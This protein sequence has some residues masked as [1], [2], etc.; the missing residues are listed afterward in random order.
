MK[1][2]FTTVFILVLSFNLFS[3]SLE[4]NNNPDNYPRKYYSVSFA[5]G[6]RT[7]NA[8]N[9]NLAINFYDNNN[10]LVKTITSD[11]KGS[12]LQPAFYFALNKGK[13]TGL[14]HR[15]FFDYTSGKQKSGGMGYSLSWNFPFQFKNTYLVLRTGVYAMIGNTLLNLKT[16]DNPNSDFHIGDNK[17]DEK[18]I[19][20]FLTSDFFAV[21][22]EIEARY[23]VNRAI[24]AFFLFTYDLV[25]SLSKQQESLK[26][27]S[28]K[29]TN[30]SGGSN[31]P[32]SREDVELI[33]DGNYLDNI[34]FKYG[35][36]RLSIG[37]SFVWNRL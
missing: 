18:K 10:N 35:N 29:S 3:Q 9:G 6:L 30:D 33:L 20:M 21:G 17:F 34:P 22:P 19:R 27:V 25:N 37:V 14:A 7:L 2:L 28:T 16:I 32:L 23:F 15:L 1:N 26:F 8:Q 36:L 13:Y 11:I 12:Y 4:Y 5:T 24:N 31:Y